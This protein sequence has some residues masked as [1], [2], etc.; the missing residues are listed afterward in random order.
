MNNVFLFALDGINYDAASAYAS[1]LLPAVLSI[2]DN[3]VH[4]TKTHY[5]SRLNRDTNNTSEL[6]ERIYRVDVDGNPRRIITR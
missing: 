5:R 2:R 6:F 3:T 4:S 1:I